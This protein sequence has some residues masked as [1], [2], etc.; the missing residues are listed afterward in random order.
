MLCG[1]AYPGMY[2]FVLAYFDEADGANISRLVEFYHLLADN[3]R[4]QEKHPGLAT[5]VL[6][7]LFKVTGMVRVRD[8]NLEALS[9]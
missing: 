4:L 7:V 6:Q 9:C 2:S 5:T 3:D 1:D 8:G